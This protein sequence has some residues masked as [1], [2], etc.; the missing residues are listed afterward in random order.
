MTSTD[1]HSFVSLQITGDELAPREIS[2]VLGIT[3]T[4]AYV[5]GES[6]QLRPTSRPVRG[7]T[8]VWYFHT[9]QTQNISLN[10]HLWNLAIKI[11]HGNL[12]RSREELIHRMHEIKALIRSQK[13]HAV[14][15]CF[16][17]GPDGAKVPDIDR[18]LVYLFDLMGIDIEMDFARD[19][20]VREP[21]YA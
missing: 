17:H 20:P 13:A 11:L 8:G 18:T 19:P 14:V 7:R 1:K 2:A 4:Q 12:D 16:W 5:R 15:S 3:P 9:D 21:A 10:D 6:Y